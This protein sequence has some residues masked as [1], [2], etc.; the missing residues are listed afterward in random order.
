MLSACAKHDAGDAGTRVARYVIVDDRDG[1]GRADQFSYFGHW[2][3]VRGRHDGRRS[4][5]STRSFT[6]GDTVSLFYYGR[7]CE[8]FGVAGPQGGPATLVDGT[9]HNISF[10]ARSVEMKSMY[11]G[12]WLADG[13]HTIVVAVGVQT[14]GSAPNGYVNIDY[15]R[16][17]R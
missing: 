16:I 11:L 2:E 3:R 12:P 14:K 4:G 10:H 13:P 5:T 8:L 6:P 15:A 9:T 7:R 1:G 17:D